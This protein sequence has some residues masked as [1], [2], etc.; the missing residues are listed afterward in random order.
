VL[1][2]CTDRLEQAA[3]LVALGGRYRWHAELFFRWFKSI[4]GARRLLALSQDGLTLQL[5]AGRIA[6]PL[7]SL[8]AGHKPTTRTFGMAG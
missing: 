5:D 4:L 1:P 6:S 8:W 7:I 3:E 2:L